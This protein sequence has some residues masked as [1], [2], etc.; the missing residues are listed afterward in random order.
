MGVDNNAIVFIGST[1][2]DLINKAIKDGVESV[3][4]TYSAIQ[5]YGRD[6]K[7]L[8][9]QWT[10]EEFELIGFEIANSGPY[11]CVEKEPSVVSEDINSRAKR[12]WELTGLTPK[13]YI[14][15][16]QW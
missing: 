16:Y 10:N 8:D 14:M 4:D 3:E 9:Y 5:Y 11:G 13:I 1:T 15:N 12:F 6:C 7:E 2:K